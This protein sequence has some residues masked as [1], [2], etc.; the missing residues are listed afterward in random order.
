MNNLREIGSKCFY[1]QHLAQEFMQKLN[2]A[3][4]FADIA[5]DKCKFHEEEFYLYEVEWF[6]KG[7]EKS[8]ECGSHEFKSSVVANAYKQALKEAG[9]DADVT[10]YIKGKFKVEWFKIA[11]VVKKEVSCECETSYDT[12]VTNV[13]NGR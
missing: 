9:F 12:Q 6:N 4:F 7:Q 8:S 1:S 2:Q 11:D 13:L 3:G 10:E 5:P